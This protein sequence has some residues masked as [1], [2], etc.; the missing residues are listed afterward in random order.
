[1]ISSRVCFNIQRSPTCLEVLI[2]YKKKNHVIIF[3][4]YTTM[5][6]YLYSFFDNWYTDTCQYDEELRD[7]KIYLYFL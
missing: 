3:M 6:K 5:K 7:L 1:M 4:L 2:V